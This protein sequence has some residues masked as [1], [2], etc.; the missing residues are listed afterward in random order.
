MLFYFTFFF[1]IHI[2]INHKIRF[3]KIRNKKYIPCTGLF[4][5]PVVL[6][7]SLKTFLVNRTLNYNP[8]CTTEQVMKIFWKFLKIRRITEYEAA[9]Q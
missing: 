2:F 6:L 1:F 3:H 4:A 7:T 5:E 9:L 8:D